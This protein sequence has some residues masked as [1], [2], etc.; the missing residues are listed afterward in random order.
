MI[1]IWALNRTAA[2]NT[3]KTD[4]LCCADVMSVPLGGIVARYRTWNTVQRPEIIKKVS[5]QVFV[6]VSPRYVRFWS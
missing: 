4:S 5:A 2:C 3:F 6:A 1:L